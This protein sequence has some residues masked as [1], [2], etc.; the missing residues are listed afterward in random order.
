[1]PLNWGLQRRTNCRTSGKTTVKR[2]GVRRRHT[3]WFSCKAGKSGKESHHWKLLSTQIHNATVTSKDKQYKKGLNKGPQERN[4]SL[5]SK[6]KQ[7]ER[8]QWISF[9]GGKNSQDKNWF[10]PNKWS[11]T[12]AERP[13][14]LCHSLAHPCTLPWRWAQTWGDNSALLLLPLAVGRASVDASPCL[15]AVLLSAKHEVLLIQ[16]GDNGRGGRPT[17]ASCSPSDE[18]GRSSKGICWSSLST[19]TLKP[20]PAAYIIILH[21][22]PHTAAYREICSSRTVDVLG[23]TVPLNFCTAQHLDTERGIVKCFQNDLFFFFFAKTVKS[24]LLSKKQLGDRKNIFSYNK[25]QKKFI[26]LLPIEQKPETQKLCLLQQISPL[27]IKQLQPVLSS[28]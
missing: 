13:S 1:M 6:W 5:Q 26:H 17:P 16:I 9:L 7:Q 27:L 2:D 25:H 8:K 4:L 20:Q 10:L 11:Q 23:P 14:L 21:P 12:S 19:V 28:V 15:W 22:K 24:F 18:M 3:C